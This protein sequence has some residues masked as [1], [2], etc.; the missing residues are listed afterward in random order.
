VN[1]SKNVVLVALAFLVLGTTAF[2]IYL[3]GNI[4]NELVAQEAQMGY[5]SLPAATVATAG[6]AAQPA[7]PQVMSFQEFLPNGVPTIYGS[8]LGVSFDKPVES[9]E[10]LRSLDGDLY[11]DGLLKLGDLT[12]AEQES[13][14]KV[15]MSIS[16]EFCCGVDSITAADGKAACGCAHSAA[17][18][19]LAKYLIKNHRAEFTDDQVLEQLQLW[20]TMFFPKQMYQRAVQLQAKGQGLSSSVIDQI[21]DMVGGC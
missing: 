2:N 17:M 12:E 16:C 4:A 3:Q 11:D 13:Y 18:R 1:L 7:A 15:G 9:L 5:L 6:T 19:G 20:K 8:E 21:P 10:I 14:I